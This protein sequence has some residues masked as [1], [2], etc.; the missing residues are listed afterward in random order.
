VSISDRIG[1]LNLITYERREFLKKVEGIRQAFRIE[2]RG[3]KELAK[4][5]SHDIMI[6][7]FNEMK[8]TFTSE[9]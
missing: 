9:Y 5:K 2:I 7:T 3:I 8:I 4:Q 6:K 1:N